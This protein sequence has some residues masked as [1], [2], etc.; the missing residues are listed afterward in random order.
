MEHT[1]DKVSDIMNSDEGLPAGFFDDGIKP[2]EDDTNM[3]SG[4]NN[5]TKA[6]GAQS[7]APESELSANAT[8]QNKELLESLAAFETE[9][10]EL[11]NIDELPADD[12]ISDSDI[13]QEID[14]DSQAKKWSERTQH[15]VHLQS[16]IKQ[17]LEALDPNE[18]KSSMD[19]DSN[20]SSEE[21][22]SEF[23]SWRTGQI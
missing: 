22:Y 13:N 10:A 11:I 4:N 7:K 8:D 20:E 18:S 12:L 17:G 21:E 5:A 23:T 15:L 1:D 2:A 3:D 9:I 19:E 16:I 6:T 14:L